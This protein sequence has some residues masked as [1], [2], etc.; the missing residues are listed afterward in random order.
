M[1]PIGYSPPS[2]VKMKFHI[3]F[4]QIYFAYDFPY[5]ASVFN[6]PINLVA[7]ELWLFMKGFYYG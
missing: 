5:R 1:F 2:C 7:L 3:I 6:L 4:L